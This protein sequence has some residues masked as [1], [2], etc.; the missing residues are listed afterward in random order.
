MRRIAHV[1]A[2]AMLS[3][4]F[5]FGT[6]EDSTQ[7][8]IVIECNKCEALTITSDEEGTTG[9]DTFAIGPPGGGNQ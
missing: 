2:V 9:V 6:S 8:S 1:M 7:K 3:G 5:G 4:C